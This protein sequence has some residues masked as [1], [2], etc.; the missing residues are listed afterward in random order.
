MIFYT[1]TAIATMK[2]CTSSVAATEMC[3]ARLRWE[4]IT[5]LETRPSSFGGY[6]KELIEVSLKN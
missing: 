5:K 1:Y 3:W 6:F 2:W 4:Q